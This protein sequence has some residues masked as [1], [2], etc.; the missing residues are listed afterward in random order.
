MLQMYLQE[1]LLC[2]CHCYTQ[3]VQYIRLR[4]AATHV[5]MTHR[6]CR[7]VNI[8]HRAGKQ[9]WYYLEVYLKSHNI[10]S[11]ESG[12]LAMSSTH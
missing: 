3:L 12:K 8:Y 10:I 5:L 6:D 4:A 2:A 9:S 11:L 1:C 7:S